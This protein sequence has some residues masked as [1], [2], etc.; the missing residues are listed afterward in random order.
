MS[1]ARSTSPSRPRWRTVPRPAALVEAAFELERRMQRRVE[2]RL[3]DRPEAAA[4]S[5]YVSIFMLT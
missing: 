5:A 2:C 1:T 4:E 3:A